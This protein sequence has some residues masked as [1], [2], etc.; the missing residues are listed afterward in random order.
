MG[1]NVRSELENHGGISVSGPL[2]PQ[3][4]TCGSTFS[5]KSRARKE[6]VEAGVGAQDR[7]ACGVACSVLW[8]LTALMVV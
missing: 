6:R 7:A 3:H 4:P 2:Q 8:A 5:R 1:N